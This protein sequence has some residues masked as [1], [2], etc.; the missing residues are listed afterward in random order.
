MVRERE[1]ESER[2]KNSSNCYSR[3]V[4]EGRLHTTYSS[5]L[6]ARFFNN[7]NSIG[8]LFFVLLPSIEMKSIFFGVFLVRVSFYRLLRSF[9]IRLF[10][11]I[12]WM[13]L[14]EW[15]EA[16]VENLPNSCALV[17]ICKPVF[18]SLSDNQS[19]SQFE[20]DDKWKTITILENVTEAGSKHTKN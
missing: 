4:C 14:K 19:V 13:R 15:R 8:W 3:I 16:F 9:S 18:R 10:V 5:S 2:E 20:S 11:C 7:Y 17:F 6:V 12:P 1:S